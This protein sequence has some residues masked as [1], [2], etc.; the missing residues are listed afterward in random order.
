MAMF[1]TANRIAPSVAKER[2][3]ADYRR[4]FFCYGVKEGD[5]SVAAAGMALRTAGICDE[6]VR[7]PQEEPKELKLKDASLYALEL[8]CSLP[9]FAEYIQVP[10]A[11]MEK[12]EERNQ[13]QLA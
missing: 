9:N 4:A 2:F 10:D 12:L 7:K 5:P 13:R 3:S 1:L 6:V 11:E 8:M